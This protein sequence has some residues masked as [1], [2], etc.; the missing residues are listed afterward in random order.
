MLAW[1]AACSCSSRLGELVTEL[2]C[3]REGVDGA[4][5]ECLPHPPRAQRSACGDRDSERRIDGCGDR[6]GRDLDFGIGQA[7]LVGAF[8]IVHPRECTPSIDPLVMDTR[9]Q[10]DLGVGYSGVKG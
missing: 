7:T 4:L 8:G 10:R 2:H 1:W 9:F 5:A 6:C 3:A